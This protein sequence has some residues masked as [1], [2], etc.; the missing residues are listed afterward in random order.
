VGTPPRAREGVSE[1]KTITKTDEERYYEMVTHHTEVLIRVM[2][3]TLDIAAAK[4]EKCSTGQDAA[5]AIR[6]L[7]VDESSLLP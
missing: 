3:R 4:A 7:I 2:R 1:M 5:K 6:N